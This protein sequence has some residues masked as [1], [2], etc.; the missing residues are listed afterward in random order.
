MP[1][2]TTTA[3]PPPASDD[4]DDLFNYDVDTD[5]VFRDYHPAMDAPAR[6]TSPT[7]PRA[8]DLGIDEEIQV[9]KKRRPIAKLDDNRRARLLSQAGI[10]KLRRITKE[11]LKFK[12][13]KGHEYADVARLLDLY[14]LWL[15]DLYPRAKFAD[16]LA[17]IE[18]LGHTKRLQT[19]RRE[20]IKEGKPA[21]TR[22]EEAASRQVLSQSTANGGNDNRSEKSPA[23]THTA[24]PASPASRPSTSKPFKDE[25]L[26]ISD[27]EQD[28]HPSDHELDALLAE[29]ALLATSRPT[30]TTT[31][32]T[33]A[34]HNAHKADQ[35]PPSDD[36]DELD[37]LLAETPFLKTPS[38]PGT[39]TPHPPPAQ[40]D[41]FADEM[42]A[43]A[44]MDDMW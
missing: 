44:G 21:E 9:A 18:K 11:R 22:E 43:M 31:T 30:T 5:D 13:K 40:H 19:M 26:F 3:P 29:D 12:G 37:A 38:A 6:P 2:Q 36:D 41:D 28:A 27:D 17:M 10:P 15:D 23:N 16:G 24:G 7:R 33:P 34:V 8:T 39:A 42:E 20:W 32:T 1:A 4:L 25:S 14:Q 35:H